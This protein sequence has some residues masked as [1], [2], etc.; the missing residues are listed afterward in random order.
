MRM[1]ES[2]KEEMSCLM[3]NGTWHGGRWNKQ[4]KDKEGPSVDNS[5][6]HGHVRDE[7]SKWR[8]LEETKRDFVEED[9]G[10]VQKMKKIRRSGQEKIGEQKERWRW[11]RTL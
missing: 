4:K 8:G 11:G 6:S 2:W 3:E 1:M 7:G 5:I 10:F 9:E